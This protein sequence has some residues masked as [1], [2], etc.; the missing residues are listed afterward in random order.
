MSVGGWDLNVDT[1]GGHGYG[2]A[3]VMGFL[4]HNSWCCL[5]LYTIAATSVSTWKQY[6]ISK[7]WTQLWKVEV[8]LDAKLSRLSRNAY[9][10]GHL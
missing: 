4:I 1:V 6:V 8:E 2:H 3:Q 5:A 7:M 10:K 9:R